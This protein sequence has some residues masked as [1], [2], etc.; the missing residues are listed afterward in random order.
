MIQGRRIRILYII[1]RLDVGGAEGHLVQVLRRL[2]RGRFDPVLFCLSRLGPLAAEVEALGVPIEVL[3][4]EGVFRRPWAM[5]ALIADGVRRIRR[6]RPDIVHT[7]LYHP[8][9]LG[10][11]MSRLAGVPVLITSRRSLGL[12]KDGHPHLQWGEDL[13]NL[14]TDAVTV[15]SRQVELDTLARERWV[16]GKIRLIYNGVELDRYSVPGRSREQIRSEL[17]IPSD[18]PVIGCVANLYVYKGHADLIEAMGAVARRAPE[19]HLVLVGR[20][21]QMGDQVRTRAAELGLAGKVHLLGERQ[22]VPDLMHAFD[23]LVLPSH[24]EGFS[25]AILEGM[26]A[27]LPVVATDVGGNP[28]SVL[29]GETGLI[30]PPHKP[31]ALAEALVGLLLDRDRAR[32]MGA[33]GR[34]RVSTR[35]SPE[36]MVTSMQALYEELLRKKGLVGS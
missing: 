7:Y 20:E 2:D 12:Y 34:V 19:A 27:S 32:W 14:V 22:D 36:S 8:N 9:I 26:A 25:N 35:F 5:P 13:I 3:G 30:V 18:A 28:E 15:N 31:A 10:G 17:A 1:G 29:H 11:L 4:F 33:A 23:I 16:S 24:E 21:A 6:Y